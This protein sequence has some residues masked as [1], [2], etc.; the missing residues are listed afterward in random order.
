MTDEMKKYLLEQCR[1]WMLPEE[2]NALRRIGLTELGA[3]VTSKSAR[4]DPKIEKMYGFNDKNTNE[5]VQ[6]GM[7][8]MQL[9]IA[10]RLLKESGDEIIN[11]CPKCGQLARTPK[12]K[13]CRYC[14]HD[15]RF[16]KANTSV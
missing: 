2:I 8:K 6:L 3:E 16:E 15:W 14:G 7:E 13:Q 11:N 10:E 9:K 4:V 1:E 12:A 5:L